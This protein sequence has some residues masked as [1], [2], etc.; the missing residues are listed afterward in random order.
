M[1]NF[2]N[3]HDAL[4]SH[5]KQGAEGGSLE[6]ALGDSKS[7]TPLFFVALLFFLILIFT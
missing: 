1:H 5:C 3:M 6:V 4:Y 2:Y 7:L